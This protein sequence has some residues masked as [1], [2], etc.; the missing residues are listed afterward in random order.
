ME[1]VEVKLRGMRSLL[2]FKRSKDAGEVFV[3]VKAPADSPRTQVGK[4]RLLLEV[5]LFFRAQGRDERQIPLLSV[6]DARKGSRFGLDAFLVRESG[7]MASLEA[8]PSA[9]L[10]GGVVFEEG[11]PS[12]PVSLCF[13]TCCMQGLGEEGLRA[14]TYD[15]K[16]ILAVVCNPFGSLGTVP[17]RPGEAGKGTGSMRALS[18]WS[19]LF[20]SNPAS[21]QQPVALDRSCPFCGKGSKRNRRQS[22]EENQQSHQPKK[23]DK[24]S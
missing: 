6:L 5:W 19:T 13:W 2:R 23:A 20:H 12:P 11:K 1:L 22:D 16:A 9:I 15:E 17:N 4:A 7:A 8:L 24:K 10:L 3:N 21:G 18:P 14:H